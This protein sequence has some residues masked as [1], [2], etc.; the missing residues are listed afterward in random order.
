MKSSAAIFQGIG[1]VSSVRENDN[2]LSDKTAGAPGS[3]PG[4]EAERV[5]GFRKR[6][7]NARVS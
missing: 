1:Q 4:T 2:A 7:L 6:R 5:R 3:S